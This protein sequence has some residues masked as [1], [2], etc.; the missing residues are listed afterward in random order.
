MTTSV[1]LAR[2]RTILTGWLGLSLAGTPAADL[3]HLLA[4]R[5]AATGGSPAAYL[6][7]LATHRRGDERAVLAGRLTVP[8]TYLYRHVE[9]FH[10]VAEV[11]VPGRVRARGA[12]GHL[13]VLSAACAT[14]DEAYTLAMVVR[15]ALPGPAWTVQVTGVDVNPAVLRHA[16]RGRYSAWSLRATP[17]PVLR[18]WFRPDGDDLV[19]TDEIR[20]T[21]RFVDGN[22]LDGDPRWWS[23]DAYDIVFCRNALMYLTPGH[24]AAVVGRLVGALAPDGYLFLG[25]AETAYGRTAGIDLRHS[26]GTFYFQRTATAGTGAADRPP[27]QPAAPVRVSPERRAAV[28]PAESPTEA[29]LHLLRQERFVDALALVAAQPGPEALLLRAVLLTDLDRLGE[30]E[31][32]CR[33]MLDANG[34]DAGAHYLLAVCREGAGDL[35]AAEA[36]ARTAAYVDPGFAMPR[37]RL[38]L[39]A[40]R[41]GDHVTARHELAAALTLLAGERE[42]RLLL[43]GGGFTR[44][45]LTALCRTALPAGAGAP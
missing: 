18:R 11:A 36:H 30:A 3:A 25:H 22:L 21:V 24:A 38:G 6:D 31:A 43:F 15:E 2:F 40:R 28:T 42:R 39:L 35:A 17:E 16:E 14:G 27:A 44:S 7:A 4:D 45:A 32:E 8:E 12:A 41:R 37:L 1:D 19:P 13:N 29:A 26:H 34:L 20:R 10:A 9:Q 5:V 33:R 23:P